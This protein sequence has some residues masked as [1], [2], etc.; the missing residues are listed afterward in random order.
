MVN[1]DTAIR[2]TR[3]MGVETI[4]GERMMSRSGDWRKV[5]EMQQRAALRQVGAT[6]NFQSW[7]DHRAGFYD[8]EGN[9]IEEYP[10]LAIV[11]T[12]EVPDA[13]Q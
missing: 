12:A 4:I 6:E 2:V 5:V 7:E 11:M 10:H 8:D 9:L 3:E 1:D 13:S